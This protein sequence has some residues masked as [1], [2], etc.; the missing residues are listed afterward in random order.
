[1][2]KLHSAA[3]LKR[4]VVKGVHKFLQSRIVLIGQFI[5]N[6]M[7]MDGG[8]FSRLDVRRGRENALVARSTAAGYGDLKSFATEERA[9][10]RFVVEAGEC[11]R[12]DVRWQGRRILARSLGRGGSDVACFTCLFEACRCP[13]NR[14]TVTCTKSPFS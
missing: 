10:A 8:C 13:T 2:N 14:R 9:I 5:R 11:R 7:R 4:S 1:M 3:M 12:V 6:R